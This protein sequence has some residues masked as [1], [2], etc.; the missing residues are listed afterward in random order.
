MSSKFNGIRKFRNRIFHHE[1]VSWNIDAL[2]NYKNEI[3]EGIDWLDINLLKWSIG[4]FRV[5]E[6]IEKQIEIIK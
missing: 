4:I 6:V 1:S 2:K 3:I 5:E